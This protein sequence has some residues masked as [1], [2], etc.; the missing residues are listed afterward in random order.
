MKRIQTKSQVTVTYG[1]GYIL[2]CTSA[3]LFLLLSSGCSNK[4]FD[5]TQVGRFRPVP[6]VSV[7]LDTLGVAEETPV[8]WEQAQDPKPID[9]VITE[10]DYAL[11]SGDVVR[12]S[13]FELLQE[14]VPFDNEYVV[15][16]TGKLS[17]PEVGVVEA[18]GLTETQLEDEVRRVLSPSVL[19]EP[20]VVVTL[21]SSQQRTFSILGEG[22]PTPGRYVIPRYGF[23]LT[24]ALATAGGPRQFN[25]S[26]IYVSRY[27]KEKEQGEL[28]IPEFKEPGLQP[29]E[30]GEGELE[31][32][33]PEAAAPGVTKP[34][35]A[36]PLIPG[37]E[38][39]EV[40]LPEITESEVTVPE[41]T[42]P[43][44][45]G[46]G[47]AEPELT[48]PET[49]E[50]EIT[51]PEE[52]VEPE[53]KM[54]EI[55]TPRAQRQ[56][57]QSRV[58]ITS[59]EMITDRE[60]AQATFPQGFERPSTNGRRTNGSARSTTNSFAEQINLEPTDEAIQDESVSVRDILKSL[61]ERSRRGQTTAAGTPPTDLVAPA[62]EPSVLA[63]E[64]SVT[65][66]E[67]PT[68]QTVEEM[69]TPQRISAEDVQIPPAP[70]PQRK[71]NG[72]TGAVESVRPS[73]VSTPTAGPK[74]SE[75][76][77]VDDILKRLSER[78]RPEKVEEEVPEEGITKPLPEPT[79]PQASD[80]EINVDEI[81]KSLS[82]RRTERGEKVEG[83]EEIVKPVEE[84]VAP[85]R[86][87]ERIDVDEILKMLEE[88]PGREKSK[89]R[90]KQP[91]GIEEAIEAPPTEPV[92][93]EIPEEPAGVEEIIAPEPTPSP[94]APGETA[95]EEEGRIEWI[96]QNG[97]WVPVQVGPEK[98]IEPVIRFEP[99][100]GLIV[101]LEEKP[102]PEVEWAEAAKT[103]LIRIPADRLLAGDPRYNIV[104]K[105]GDT[106][107]VPVDII[108]EFCIMGNV[109]SQGYVNITG[110]PMTLKMAIAAA[111]GLGPL[112]WPRK[113]EVVRRIGR[114]KEEIV[115]VDLDKIASGEQPDF[116][117]KPN[118]L[119]N[120]GTHAT[121]MW[122]AVLRNSFRATYGFGFVYDRNFADIDYYTR[123]T[124]WF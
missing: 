52:I 29:V 76:S 24:D 18:A 78:R 90:V 35:A 31:L 123:G 98:R 45:T 50:P 77:K 57:P 62:E 55:I 40:T 26:Y 56:W 93:P 63:E 117:I 1:T 101:P 49:S 102:A 28:E 36:K 60:L 100:E 82:Q 3:M 64:P 94:V 91:I 15:T 16:E 79:L 105:P 2:S 112:A 43:E 17:I 11:R 21:L 110:R 66:E 37:L 30:P 38:T 34:K 74:V 80:E 75:Q 32:L 19:K 10:S 4:F 69:P 71:I 121:S 59:S 84:P 124:K 68:I 14:G 119:V 115:L 85:Q 108:G 13:I 48:I 111:G 12:V 67:P 65:A 7:I 39:T 44:I 97:K 116:F 109:N 86:V 103:R 106:V 53:L 89:V 99:N 118:D 61:S 41:I 92:I 22:V 25:V 96:F 88:Q 107:H 72:S 33:T 8:A 81:L 23:R 9:T 104:I 70:A 58:V 122:R 95:V 51:V 120:V 20:S 6:A 83:V 54:P 42:V 73:T 46:P 47:I 27:S 5:P 113:C 87:K 114:K